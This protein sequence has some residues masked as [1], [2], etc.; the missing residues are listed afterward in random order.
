MFCSYSWWRMSC[1]FPYWTLCALTLV[2]AEMHVRSAQYGCFLQLLYVVLSRYVGQI[3]SEWF[4]DG[5]RC[6]H[7]YSY[8]FCF[9]FHISHISIAKSLHC[10]IIIQHIFII[11]FTNIYRV[12]GHKNVDFFF[13]NSHPVL[14]YG[15]VTPGF[16]QKTK[17]PKRLDSLFWNERY[18]QIFV[19]R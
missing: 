10:I 13:Q 11:I 7:N 4:W 12:T 14:A 18:R 17:E 1:N 19:I 15:E 5:S 16:R 9:T 6:P 8:H 2:L 3:F